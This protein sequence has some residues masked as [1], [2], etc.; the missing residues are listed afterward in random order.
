VK[1]LH[2][3]LDLVS[4][5]NVVK[6]AGIGAGVGAL[7]GSNKGETVKNSL[8]GA[9]VGAALAW[10]LDQAGAEQEPTKEV[11]PVILVDSEK[12]KDS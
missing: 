5:N 4:T 3:L 2:D 11:S 12:H 10:A 6:G 7:L 8:V 9:G 1:E